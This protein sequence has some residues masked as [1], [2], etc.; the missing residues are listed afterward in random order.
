MLLYNLRAVIRNA[1]FIIL[2]HKPLTATTFGMEDVGR[3][4]WERAGGVDM[5]FGLPYGT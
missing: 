1:H 5:C 2:K 4:G 3:E